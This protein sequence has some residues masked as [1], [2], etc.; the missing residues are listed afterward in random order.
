VEQTTASKA[1]CAGAL[2][3]DATWAQLQALG[4][5]TAEMQAEV[6]Q[7]AAVFAQ[8]QAS[9]GVT[10]MGMPADWT[11]YFGSNDVN[12]YAADSTCNGTVT[13]N[14]HCAWLFNHYTLYRSGIPRTTYTTPFPA[15]SGNNKPAD[16]WVVDLGP[17]P[18]G[19]WTSSSPSLGQFHWGWQNGSKV[20]F[21]SNKTDTFYP[22]KFPLD[23]WSVTKSGV[24]RGAFEIHGGRNAHDFWSM[25]THG[26]VRMPSASVTSLK[27]LWVNYTDNKSWSPGP[28]N[29]MH[30]AHP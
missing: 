27:A 21:V 8:A 9:G 7:T 15:R 19:D 20:G 22:G 16:D 25:Y 23:P 18:N 2:I 14:N 12:L 24:T 5:S 11:G 17:A 1:H 6:A 3:C 30:F 13:Y 26:C 28:D 4:F 10:P 29:P